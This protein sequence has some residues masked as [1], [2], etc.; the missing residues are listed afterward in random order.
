MSGG[1]DGKRDVTVQFRRGKTQKWLPLSSAHATLVTATEDSGD[2]S[3]FVLYSFSRTGLSKEMGKPKRRGL[4][5][6]ISI[7]A[8]V[9]ALVHLRHPDWAIDGKTV[10]LLVIAILPWLGSIFESVELPGGWKVRY[11]DL[12][13]AEIEAEKIGLVSPLQTKSEPAYLSIAEQD[14]NLALAGLRIELE[15]RLRGIA[16][17]KGL[18]SGRLSFGQLLRRLSETQAIS[19]QERSVLADLSGLLNNAVHGAKVEPRAMEWAIEVGPQI[20][21]ALDDRLRNTETSK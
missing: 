7:V 14:P 17:A 9:A 16:N 12:K 15:K 2:A 8:V 3:G 4:A 1:E 6:A 13:N 10:A 5:V 11:R 18:D 21:A 19:E 20:L